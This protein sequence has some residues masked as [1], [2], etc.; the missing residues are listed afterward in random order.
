MTRFRYGD[1]A[2]AQYLKSIFV[3]H[4]DRVGINPDTQQL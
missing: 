4:N 1:L 2:A 3:H